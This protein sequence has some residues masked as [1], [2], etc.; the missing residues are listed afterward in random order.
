M[1]RPGIAALDMALGRGRVALDSLPAVLE[2]ARGLKSRAEHC[3]DTL[4]RLQTRVAVGRRFQPDQSSL[5]QN[6][7]RDIS[8]PR[9]ALRRRIAWLSLRLFLR[10]ARL[11]LMI[12][13]LLIAIAFA[14]DWAVQNR[15]WLVDQLKNMLSISSLDQ[16]PSQGQGGAD[17]PV[18]AVPDAPVGAVPVTSGLRS[19][20]RT[21]GPQ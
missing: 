15:D 21:V 6:F 20:G 3:S 7:L 16:K 8:R 11:W 1:K 17:T 10:W 5:R 13:L 19:D 12:L 14:V 2:E 4:S 18:G 9:R